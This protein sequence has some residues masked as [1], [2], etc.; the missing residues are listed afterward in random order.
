MHAHQSLLRLRELRELTLIFDPELTDTDLL[1]LSR[2]GGERER[3]RFMG[4]LLLDERVGLR[5]RGE[6]V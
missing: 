2:E 3:E 1:A 5:P 6:G 4:D